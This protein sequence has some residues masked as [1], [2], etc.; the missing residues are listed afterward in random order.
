MNYMAMV[1]KFHYVS[2]LY[3]SQVTRDQAA[4]GELDVIK[5]GKE[6][7]NPDGTSDAV[8]KYL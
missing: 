6:K 2:I 5:R 3:R 7:H 8:K 1:F 4:Y